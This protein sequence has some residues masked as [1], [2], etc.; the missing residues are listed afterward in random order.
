MTPKLDDFRALGVKHIKDLLTRVKK[1][2]KLNLMIFRGENTKSV[3]GYWLKSVTG[4]G[5][6]GWPKLPI[7]SNSRVA[8]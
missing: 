7:G 4:L 8:G 5:V 3:L 1:A 2:T 6:S